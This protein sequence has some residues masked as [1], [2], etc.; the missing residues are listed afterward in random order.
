VIKILGSNKEL[1]LHRIRFSSLV[2]SPVRI[3]QNSV[4]VGKIEPMYLVNIVPRHHTP[5]GECSELTRRAGGSD[6]SK[7]R[8]RGV[9]STSILKW[10]WRPSAGYAR[11]VAANR[12]LQDSLSRILSG[13]YLD[14]V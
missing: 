9:K 4:L 1:H 11:R 2:K 14:F 3:H 6:G 10:F 8:R 5:R 13:M 7:R 12:V